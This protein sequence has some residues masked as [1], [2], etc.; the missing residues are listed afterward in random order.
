MS[1][2]AFLA[3]A[4]AASL[5][6]GCSAPKGNFKYRVAVIPKG[7]THEHW[8]SVE[9]G[10]RRAA[11]D[12]GA[13]GLPVEV[14]YD[15]PSKES[16]DLEQMTLVGT[17]VGRGVNG[18]VLAPQNSK[19]MVRPVEQAVAGGV[20]VVI[21]D[22]GLDPEALRKNPDLIV[23]Y[24]ATDNY[25]G[26]RLAGEHL[27]KSLAGVDKPRVILVRYAVGS[28]STEQREQGFL[29]YV[30]EQRKAGRDVR[31]VHDQTYAGAT[32]DS[33][34][35][36]AGP[37]LS[38]WGDKVDGIFAVNES[39]TSG[40]LNA[41]RSQQRNKKIKLMGFDQSAP[42]LQALRE[43]DVEGLVVQDPYR[44][45]Y[46]AVWHLVQHLEGKDVPGAGKDVSTGEYVVTRANLDDVQTRER[47]D[48]ELQQKRVIEVP[49]A[50]GK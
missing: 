29:D 27:L 21:I 24:V 46:L 23:K 45:G 41:L 35:D 50:K 48:P 22:S 42:L 33:A 49:A 44:M 9:R 8:Q 25:R 13:R 32:V 39:S 7:L 4:V 10:A 12:F 31:V 37:L 43:G 11:A 38:Q 3:V 5:A 30:A 40:L 14:L 1:R 47:F 19:Q 28:E 26:G 18:L 15:G 20:P 6:C 36:A 2:R 34:R 17:M 16:D